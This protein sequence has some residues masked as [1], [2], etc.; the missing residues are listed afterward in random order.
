M[1][2]KVI[3]NTSKV[4]QV[5]NKISSINTEINNDFDDMEE[6]VQRLNKNWNSEAN[7]HVIGKFHSI[8]GALKQSRYDVLDNY[9]RFL[10][11]QVSDGYE[12]TENANTKLSD[13]FK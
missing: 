8:K 7:S 2:G 3:V 13:A 9:S 1:A 11:E 12:K 5:A 4:V 6:W 10:K